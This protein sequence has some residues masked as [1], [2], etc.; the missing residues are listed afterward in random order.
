MFWGKAKIGCS[1]EMFGFQATK[2]VY[3]IFYSWGSHPDG[4]IAIIHSLGTENGL[5]GRA[6]LTIILCVL[7]SYF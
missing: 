4:I 1:P 7:F 5:T 6:G 2:Y 3:L